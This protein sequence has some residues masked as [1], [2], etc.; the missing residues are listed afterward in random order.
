MF[1]FPQSSSFE[2]SGHPN[3]YDYRYENKKREF[4]KERKK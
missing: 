3:D 4:G 1:K 2:D